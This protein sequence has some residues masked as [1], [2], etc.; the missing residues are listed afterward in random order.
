MARKKSE[1][2]R[3]MNKMCFG[4][5]LLLMMQRMTVFWM[6]MTSTRG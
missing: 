6:M 4:E 3:E 5:D 2:E 1:I